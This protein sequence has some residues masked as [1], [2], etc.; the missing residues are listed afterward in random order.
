MNAEG[1]NLLTDRERVTKLEILIEH[2]TK[3]HLKQ[4]PPSDFLNQLPEAEHNH[5]VIILTKLKI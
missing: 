1:H 2:I 3:C 5:Q 4:G